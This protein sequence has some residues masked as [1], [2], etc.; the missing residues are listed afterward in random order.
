LL[1]LEE[2]EESDERD[3]SGLEEEGSLEDPS[4]P[5]DPEEDELG[6]EPDPVDSFAD[7]PF[8][9]SLPVFAEA[10]TLDE[11]PFRESFE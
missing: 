11:D 7:E 6:S 8:E 1:P 3:P 4:G 10:A 9:P 2:D 5:L